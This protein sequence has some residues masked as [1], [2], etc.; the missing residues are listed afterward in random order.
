MSPRL[1][2]LLL[3]A[4]CSM[5]PAGEDDERERARAHGG[6]FERPVAERTLPEVAETAPL[7]EWVR[8]AL[9]ASP[10]L[11]VEYWKWR[12][13]IER[14]PQASTQESTL[15]LGFES[16]VSSG[17]GSFAERSALLA[18]TDSAFGLVWPGKLA[19]QGRAALE[20]ARAAGFHFEQMRGE[21]ASRTVTAFVEL[22]LVQAEIRI[23]E[24]SLALL[25][26]QLPAIEARVRSGAALQ[27]EL[28]RARTQIQLGA[29]DL[30]SKRGKEPGARARLNAITAREVGMAASVELPPDEPLPFAEDELLHRL[31]AHNPELAEHAHE[32]LARKEALAAAELEWLPELSLSASIGKDVTALGAALTAPILR[33]PAISGAI[34]EAKA[35]VAEA[36]AYRRQMEK[37]MAADALQ[38]L[39]I[40]HSAGVQR[41]LFATTILPSA[42]QTLQLVRA[43]YG[44]SQATFLEL[45]EAQRTLLEARLAQVRLAGERTRSRAQLLRIAAHTH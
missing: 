12:A 41:S 42:E 22:A 7:A 26:A 18:S 17:A 8:R 13:A 21:L 11:E 29:A 40:F 36:E 45:T 38:E 4:A 28:L 30:A 43:A 6:Q 16:I 37:D 44:L 27:Q 2:V 33:A 23:G 1:T 24:E 9:L 32:I 3:L 31:F 10:A 5:R 25:R 35:W 39:A 15:E 19:A 20:E 14:I 34:A